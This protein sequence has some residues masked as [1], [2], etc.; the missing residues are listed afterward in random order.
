MKRLADLLCG[1]PY[2]GAVILLI[3]V[4]HWALK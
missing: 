3:L 2:V 1:A 4:L